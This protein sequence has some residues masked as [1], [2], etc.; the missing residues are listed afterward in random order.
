MSH[1]ISAADIRPHITHEVV[2]TFS[3]PQDKKALHQFVGLIINYYHRFVPRCAEILQPLHLAL[4]D[5]SFIWTAS[6]QQ[7]FEAAK[8]ALFEAVMLVHPQQ[9]APTCITTDASN[10]AVGAVLEHFINGQWKPISFF[11]K[12]LSPAELK[13]SAFDHELLAAYLAVQHF[14]YF[15]EGRVFNINTDRKPLTFALNSSAER[16]SPR[17]A[18]HLAFISE[19]MTDLRC[20]KGQ[21]NRVADALSRNIL[22]LDQSLINLDILAYAQDQASRDSC[23][24]ISER[25]VWPNMKRDIACWTRTCHHCQQ[26]KVQRHVKAPL[27]AFPLPDCRFDSI[28][29]DIVRPLPPSKG[30]TYL[31]TCIERHTRWSEAIPMV[32]ATAESCASALVPG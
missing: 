26:S 3:V 1:T 31:F 7:A 10:R 8:M 11:S 4:A 16:H 28:H 22:A 30:Y 24:L 14:Q 12:K 29:V 2:R 9:H 25:Y 13:Y 17:Q 6:C 15:V 19:F 32:D 5:D 18:L 23:H 21:A 20:I 27:K